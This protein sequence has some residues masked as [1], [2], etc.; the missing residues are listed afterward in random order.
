MK[1]AIKQESNNIPVTNSTAITPKKNDSSSEGKS[2]VSEEVCHKSD[3][4]SNEPSQGE[5]LLSLRFLSFRERIK[6]KHAYYKKHT[7]GMTKKER[8]GYFLYYYKWKV[9]LIALLLFCAITIPVS[10]YRNTRP[11]ALSYAIINNSS[12]NKINKEVFQDYLDTYGLNDGYR[13]SEYP[14]IR[15]SRE[16]YEKLNGNSTNN[17]S[18]DQFP[19]LCYNGYIDIIITDETG[20]SFCSNAGMLQALDTAMPREY[21]DI[22]SSDYNEYLVKEKGPENQEEYYAIDISDTEFAKSLNL[23][24]DRIYLCFPGNKDSEYINVRRFLNYVF[25]LGFEPY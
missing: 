7:E 6:A 5:D 1:D 12:F 14:D 20:L 18:Y 11:V 4:A 22:F 17:A 21:Y 8:I 2:T 3:E 16:E 24:Y 23:S 10:I 15:L 13:L 25:S 9:C 19:T